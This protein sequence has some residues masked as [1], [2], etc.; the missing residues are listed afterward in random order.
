MLISGH[1]IMAFRTSGT[2]SD[3]PPHPIL[4]HLHTADTR[5]RL[6]ISAAILLPPSENDEYMEISEF[7]GFDWQGLLHDGETGTPKFA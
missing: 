3:H 7:P 2:T 6:C 5:I 4:L 1:G